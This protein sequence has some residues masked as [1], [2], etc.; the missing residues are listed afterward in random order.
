[1]NHTLPTLHIFYRLTPM[2]KISILFIL[3][4]FLVALVSILLPEAWYQEPSGSSLQKPD[5][6][7]LL[8]TDDLGV[9]LLAQIGHGATV[10]LTVGFGCTFLATGGGLFFGL[11][12]GYYGKFLDKMLMGIGDVIITLPQL[13]LIIILGAYWGPSLKNIILIISLLS[14]IGPAR[15]IRARVQSVGKEPYI[16]AAQSYGAKFFHIFKRHLFREVLP[17]VLVDAIRIFSHAIIAEA[18]LTFLGLGDPTSK[19]WGVILNRSLAFRGIFFT[20]FWK[21]WVLPPLIIL[22]L[23]VIALALVGKNLEK[24]MNKKL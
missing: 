24:M 14:W 16:I 4:V 8:G 2:G 6:T 13:P 20:D 19:S 22:T 17:I 1:M 21:W 23:F 7:H 10:S 15:A 18:G 11:L 5:H 9:D 12:A 3:L